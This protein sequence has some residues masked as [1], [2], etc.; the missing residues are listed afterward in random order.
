MSLTN[1]KKVIIFMIGLHSLRRLI[2]VKKMHITLAK[3]RK[4]FFIMELK[5]LRLLTSNFSIVITFL[6]PFCARNRNYRG[7]TGFNV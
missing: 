6:K 5:T 3:Y 1:I 4:P 7:A 2:N